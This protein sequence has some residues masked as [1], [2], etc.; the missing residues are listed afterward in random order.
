[1]RM[2]RFNPTFF[3][4]KGVGPS[5]PRSGE[6]GFLRSISFLSGRTNG[7]V[8][9]RRPVSIRGRPKVS[10]SRFSIEVVGSILAAESGVRVS[11]DSRD[12]G[13]RWAVKLNFC[14]KP[15]SSPSN[16]IVLTPAPSLIVRWKPFFFGGWGPDDV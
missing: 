11:S 4:F 12:L 16:F 3:F 1:M 7:T 2:G 6:E 5:A 8:R 9:T 10:A 15:P 13:R 14:L